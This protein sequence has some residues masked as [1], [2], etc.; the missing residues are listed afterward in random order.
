MAVSD[1]CRTFKSEL[2]PLLDVGGAA[3]P[4]KSLLS[5]LLLKA[6]LS[7]SPLW[8]Q[9][10]YMSLLVSC[11]ANRRSISILQGCGRTKKC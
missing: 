9:V 4:L 11:H 2:L 7:S 8:K 6:M 10:Q 3:Q 1:L 5:Q